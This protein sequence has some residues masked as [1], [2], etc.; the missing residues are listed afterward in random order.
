MLTRFE[1]VI[2]MPAVRQEMLLLKMDEN[3][4]KQEVEPFLPHIVFFIER[5]DFKIFFATG[6]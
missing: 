1:S 5:F 3:D 6:F 2:K 4:M